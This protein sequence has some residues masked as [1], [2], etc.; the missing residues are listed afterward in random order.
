MRIEEIILAALLAAF[1]ASIIPRKLNERQKFIEAAA[2]FRKIFTQALLD[3]NKDNGF[4]GGYSIDT[5]SF[6]Q[7]PVA[8][9]TFR[10]FLKGASRNQYDEAW[11]QYCF[12][13]EYQFHSDDAFRN[14]IVKDIEH[15]LEFTEYRL[16]QSISFI[17][18]ETWW[19]IRFKLFGPDKET[20]ELLEKFSKNDESPKK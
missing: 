17:C 7:I 12:D 15:L 10:Y 20:K 2:E 14:K 5:D 13:C 18:R 19:K 3:I 11:E 1:F 6:K 9:H 8:Y 4:F 16:F